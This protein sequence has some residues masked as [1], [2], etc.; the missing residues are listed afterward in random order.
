MADNF[1]AARALEKS[2]YAMAWNGSYFI[3]TNLKS[4]GLRIQLGHCVGEK[5]L[6]PQPAFAD[7]FVVIDVNG[8]HDVALDFCNCEIAQHHFVQLLRYRWLPATVSNPKTACTF[9]ALKHFQLLSFESKVSGFEYHKHWHFSPKDRYRSLMVMI[10]IYRHIKMLKRSGKGHDPG[11]AAATKPGE[12]AVLC[13]ACPQPQM[14]L[15][16]GWDSDKSKR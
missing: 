15:P 16:M 6:S 1:Y 13:P 2:I 8:I 9:R 5:C 14:N 7:G 12:C 11:G 3:E 4:L 10:R